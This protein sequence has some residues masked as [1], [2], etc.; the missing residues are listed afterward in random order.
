MPSLSSSIVIFEF[1]PFGSNDAIIL[2]I[3][4]SN[5][6]LSGMIAGI[7]GLPGLRDCSFTLRIPPDLGWFPADLFVRL[8]YGDGALIVGFDKGILNDLKLLLV[9][10]LFNEVFQVNQF[11]SSKFQ[12]GGL[13]MEIDALAWM[14]M[15]WQLLFRFGS[16][17]CNPFPIGCDDH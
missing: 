2:V 3:V 9:M 17:V 16:A 7:S 5:G 13:L 12:H 1:S 4:P 15:C 6:S 10:E 8:G 14:L 11:A